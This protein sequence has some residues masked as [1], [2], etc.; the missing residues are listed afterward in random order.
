MNEC[1]IA[2]LCVRMSLQVLFEGDKRE[3][4]CQVS[5]AG[6]GIDTSPGK[7]FLVLSSCR[8]VTW[9]PM[10]K[11]VCRYPRWGTINGFPGS[12]CA[13]VC[14]C[15]CQVSVHVVNVYMV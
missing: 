4:M 10:G 11:V 1:A 2:F 15:V 7:P 5:S 13:G 8:A 3:Y 6:W 14:V 9:I 12:I